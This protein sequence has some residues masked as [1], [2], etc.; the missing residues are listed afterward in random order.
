MKKLTLLF[1]LL[2]ASVMGMRA[3]V[4][5]SSQE[6][7]D[8]NAF[9][10]AYDYSFSTNGTDVTLSFTN[11]DNVSGLVG[12]LW[13]FNPG[14]TEKNMTVSGKTAS[15]TLTDQTPGST[16]EFACKFA[17]AA[18]ANHPMGMSVTKHFTYIVEGGGSTPVVTGI[19]ESTVYSSNV[20]GYDIH[21]KVTKGC[22]KYYLTISSATE[23][24]TITGLVGDNMFC[25]RYCDEARTHNNNYHMAAAGHYTLTDGKVIFTIPSVGDPK[26]YTPLNLRFNDNQVVEVT[27]LNGA[28]LEP[29]SSEDP[30]SCPDPDPTSIEDVNFALMSN[31]AVA[32]ASTGNA[33]EAIDG[34]DGSRW[35]SASSDPQWYVV[36]LG[37]RRIFNTVQI[38]WQTAYSRTFTI[39]VSN[40][41]ETWTTKKTE[42][43]YTD[44]GDNVEYEANFAENITARYVRLHSTARATQWGNSFFSFRVLLK[45]VPVL[46][47]V[48]LSSNTTIAKVGAY[49]TLTPSPKD[50][51]NGAIAA[52]LSYTITPADAGHVTDNKYYPEKYGLATITVTATT[53]NAEVT[54]N[55][56]EVWGVISDNL[57]YS[58]N[59]ITDNKVIDQSEVTGD[60]TSA[61]FA[62]D[63]N[64]GSVWQACRD[65]NDNKTNAN[66]TSY[67]T[68]DLG[69]VYAINLIAI[70]FDG[71]ASDEYTIE[72][73]KDNTA[74]ST[75]FSIS[76]HIGNYTHQKYLSIADLNNNDQVRYVRFTTTKAS[77]TMGWGMKMFEMEVYGT[78]ASTTK[79]VAASVLPA[80]T[81]S[82]TI[83]A[84]GNPVEEVEA[85]TE[86]TFTAI[87]AAGYD[88]VNW[89]QGG[90]VISGAGATYTTTITANTA[91]VANFEVHR[92]VYCQTA[93]MTNNNKTLYLSCSKVADDT[94][95][96]R[97]DGSDEAKINGRNNFNFVVNHATNY[98]NEVYN[99]GSGQGWQVSNEGNGYIVNTFNAADYKTLS[100]GSHYFAIGAQGGG[101]FILDNNFPLA[102][103]IAWNESCVDSEAP[104]LAAPVATALNTTDVRL[105]LSATDNW[106]GT[107]T[108]NVNYKPT[109]DTGEGVNISPAPQGASGQTI[110]VDVEGLTT[111]TEYTF[112]VTA[113]DGTNVS[114]AQTC[115]A[116]PAGDVTAPTNVTIS[117]VALTDHIVR[118]T[119]SAD[120]DY[121]GDITYN[122]A[123]D[124]AGVASTSAAQGTTT[125]LDIAGLDADADYHFV[126]VATDAANN[127]ADAVNAA[128]VHTYAT[129]LALNKPNAAGATA[130]PKVEGNDGN[131]GSRWASGGSAIHGTGADSQDWWYVD[132]GAVYDIK[133]I[134]MFWEGA[135]PSKYKFFTSNDA[136]AW[137]EI[138][139]ITVSPSY[140]AN[141]SA[142]MDYYN[143]IDADAQGRYLK[144]WGYEDTNN[145]WAYG[146]SFWELEAYGTLATDVKAPVISAFTASGASTTSVLLQATA[147]DN[148]K[149][150]L[151]YTFY[152]D[153]VAQANPVVMPAGQEA[154]Y[155]VNGLTMGTNYNF[156]VNVSDGTN[157]TMSDVVVGSPIS[158]N[159]A[160]MDVTVETKFKSDEE[161]VLTLSATDN[162][163]GLIYYTVTMGET[164][165][166]VQ[167]MSGAEVDVTFDGLDYDTPYAFSIVAKDGSD[168]AAAAVDYNE[169]TKPATYPTSAAPA[170]AFAD[171]SVRPVYS[172]A[173][174]K[175]CNFADWGGS[176]V[177]KQTYGAKK[178]NHAATYFGIFGF[179]DVKVDA[180]DELYLSVWTN[181]NISFRVVPII[182]NPQAASNLPERGAFT[183]ELIGGQWN[184]VRFTMSD[185]N[186][187]G[188]TPSTGYT[189]FDKIYQIKI[190]QAG[191][192]TFWLDNIY[193]HR[194]GALNETDNAEFIAANNNEGQD[195]TIPRT[196][197]LTTEWY[198]L[199]LPFDLS[200]ELLVEAFG[201]GYTLATLA[202]SEDHGSLISLNFDFVNSFE[203]GKAYLLRPGTAVTENPVFEGVVVKNVDP[204]SVAA[205]STYMNFQGTFNTIVLDNENQRFVGPENYLYSPAEGGTNMKAFR[206]FF[207]IPSQ[208]P[209]NGAP[210][211][212][213]RIVFGKQT[214]TGMEN[215]QGD[216]VQGT[217]VLMDGQLF[218]IR[219]G[220]IYNA[221]GTLVK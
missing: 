120:D 167:A 50:Q 169:T 152:C 57:A 124:N 35:E 151:T 63:G 215:V 133:N 150:D 95:Q 71:A 77:T 103:T 172:S 136:L 98:S 130:L 68:L 1:A 194:H 4:A 27:A 51:N 12:V 184:V 105:T 211:K 142:V 85:G 75:G 201:A 147:D 163:G 22:N 80:G 209:L 212:P 159:Q 221:Q 178:M 67:Y 207:T 37:Q 213:A 219:E 203:A 127:S 76:Q 182:D 69:T 202:T 83:T 168:N 112:T 115:K 210:A 179:G 33:W 60:A 110:T 185:F 32:Y 45:G 154:T 131:K 19:C 126:V 87:P 197:P 117:A 31:G 116:T 7:C 145:N 216:N 41:G 186:L 196:F 54:S 118:L 146:I 44:G 24:K 74:W 86:V 40:D 114:A 193:F 92:D 102:N 106:K 65:L 138:A 99:P 17:F 21:A 29:C 82:V 34:N 218:I 192:Q 43:N 90:V 113:S 143:D 170:P 47:S 88:F 59:I 52:N 125:T 23:G 180:D 38:R 134:R 42:A 97:I 161:I 156:K 66:F 9:V 189:N 72:F 28:R 6:H 140:S 181:E 46:T 135:R 30:A 155:T 175:D 58:S 217:K 188:M 108:Y 157:N 198:T 20:S 153:N 206:C 171:A 123:Y 3:E 89:T 25:N 11:N 94:Y 14:L 56:V 119:L 162:L 13:H 49:A 137:T 61:F 144:V 128:A 176:P 158:D 166:N 18:D 139:D 16:I 73:S 204:E 199:C 149:G 91:L 187:D 164:V 5:G 129:N 165:K 8:G 39:D 173:Y 160:P 220:R 122:I 26:M 214:T 70:W 10:N 104:V 141:A 101:E 100:F 48:G 96:I 195:I 177:E 55:S 64:K 111:N 208:S 2:C 81:G 183:Q 53:A 78:E 36:D 174:S 191:N 121:A 107:I 62:V 205:T 190:D 200:D 84:G 79:T 93:V 109:G 15:I 132:L 148:F